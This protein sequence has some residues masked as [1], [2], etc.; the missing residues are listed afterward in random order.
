MQH[1]GERETVLTSVSVRTVHASA[2][3]S[4]LLSVATCI[5]FSDM[6]MTMLKVVFR[7]RHHRP[8]ASQWRAN[9]K[10]CPPRKAV[11]AVISSS[12]SVKTAVPVPR[13]TA[14]AVAASSWSS[15]FLVST[16]LKGN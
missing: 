3:K 2:V 9:Q 7:A 6:L 1:I 4:N 10:C 16:Q 12:F 11:S 15:C 8:V 5:I 14:A 13:K